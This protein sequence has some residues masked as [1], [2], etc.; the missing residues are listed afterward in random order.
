MY[1]TGTQQRL[2]KRVLYYGTI[3]RIIY[4]VTQMEFICR[5]SDLKQ[6]RLNALALFQGIGGVPLSYMLSV[7]FHN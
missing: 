7:I 1:G 2:W 4:A 5:G 3:S 6:G